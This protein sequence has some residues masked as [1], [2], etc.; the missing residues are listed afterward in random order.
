[1]DD[2]LALNAVVHLVDVCKKLLDESLLVCLALL[3]LG[4]QL[5]TKAVHGITESGPCVL[6]VLLA[7]LLL[8][9]HLKLN[10]EC[11]LLE[12]LG[13]NCL[14]LDV[15]GLGD[16]ENLVSNLLLAALLGLVTALLLAGKVL[17]EVDACLVNL[18]GD[19][20]LEGTALV[21]LVLDLIVHALLEVL[22]VPH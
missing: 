8:L 11:L 1:M 20:G 18:L 14:E 4:L 5:A 7:D 13:E 3:L 9:C 22:D 10:N 21:G 15:E 16:A 17:T 19:L 2:A 12:S 6:G